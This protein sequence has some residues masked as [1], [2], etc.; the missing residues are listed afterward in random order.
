MENNVSVRR[1][2]TS[3]A[4]FLKDTQAVVI[5]DRR[6][7]RAI[8]VPLSEHPNYNRQEQRKAI[9]RAAKEMLRILGELRAEIGR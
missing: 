9:A 8:L 7:D 3:L 1:F 2:R 5:G 6:H 4:A